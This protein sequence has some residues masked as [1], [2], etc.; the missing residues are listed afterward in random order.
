MIGLQKILLM[1]LG[2]PFARN[3]AE[4][5]FLERLI[6]PAFLMQ[7]WTSHAAQTRPAASG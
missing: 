6:S 4:Q 3:L 7:H 2:A 5:D 1:R